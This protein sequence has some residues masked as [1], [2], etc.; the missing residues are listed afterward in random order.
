MRGD[1]V[2]EVRGGTV[3]GVYTNLGNVRIVLVD[4][5]DIQQGDRGGEY[6]ACC[7]ADMPEHTKQEYRYASEQ[8][9]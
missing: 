9:Q 3:V 1:V 4:W 7:L 5:D 8:S 2:V 6:P